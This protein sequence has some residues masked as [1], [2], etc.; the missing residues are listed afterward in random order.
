[1]MHDG[2]KTI[3]RPNK[4]SIG[5]CET[6]FWRNV[7][8]NLSYTA[9]NINLWK[10]YQGMLVMTSEMQNISG[11]HCVFAISSRVLL[12]LMV[13]NTLKMSICDEFRA[14]HF[15]IPTSSLL[16]SLNEGPALTK[17]T[18]RLT[19]V[20]AHSEFQFSLNI[21]L[22]FSWKPALCVIDSRKWHHVVHILW[23]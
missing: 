21:D 15:R 9:E 12:I 13:L 14:G 18:F 6:S 17:W 10:W 1:M 2:D 4:Q 16:Y 19:S 23:F 8:R 7:N 5:S 11:P 3:L 22:S 20:R